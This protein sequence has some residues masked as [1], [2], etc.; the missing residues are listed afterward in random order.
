MLE[1]PKHQVFG[2][3]EKVLDLPELVLGLPEKVLD[4]PELVPRVETVVVRARPRKVILAL[5]APGRDLFRNAIA[6]VFRPV[7]VVLF[8]V[9]LLKI[10]FRVELLVTLGA[11]DL[12]GNS[13][14]GCH[15]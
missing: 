9:V 4:L 7:L 10:G 6:N 1:I 15:A 8:A 5:L 2:Q 14:I 12:S 3:P 11:G 13:G